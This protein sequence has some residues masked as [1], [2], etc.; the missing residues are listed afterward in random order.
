MRVEDLTECGLWVVLYFE[1][2]AEGVGEWEFFEEEMTR[3]D[4]IKEATASGRHVNYGRAGYQLLRVKD[5]PSPRLRDDGGLED[6]EDDD[7]E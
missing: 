1:G 5:A 7:Y 3:E 2:N 6:G 4:A